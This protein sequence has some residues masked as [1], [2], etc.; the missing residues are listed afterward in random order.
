[1]EKNKLVKIRS[2]IKKYWKPILVVVY[3]ISPI[4][5]IPDV[6]LPL[7]YTDDV[8]LILSLILKYFLESKKSSIQF[9]AES[10]TVDGEIVD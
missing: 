1:M 7:G 8:L 9:D 2:F 5:I 3:L 4:D 6:L 10:Q